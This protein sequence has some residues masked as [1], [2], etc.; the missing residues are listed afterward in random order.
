[1][2]SSECCGTCIW[3]D[4]DKEHNDFFC[5]NNESEYVGDYT[6][7]RDSCDEYEER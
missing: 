4:Y 3:H 7:Y 6:D 5:A 2:C 1:M